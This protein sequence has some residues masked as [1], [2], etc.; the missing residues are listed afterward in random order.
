MTPMTI[1]VI[2]GVLTTLIG[3]LLLAMF[4][5]LTR[6]ERDQRAANRLNAES[7]QS[8]QRAEL[9]RM[10]ERV[11]EDGKPVTVEEMEHATACYNAYHASGG[12][13]TGTLLFERIKEHAIIVTKQ[14]KEGTD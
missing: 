8:M 11:V 12:N 4:R 3:A 9:M 7:I 2:T 6:F 10:F 1:S 5:R 13:G 14:R